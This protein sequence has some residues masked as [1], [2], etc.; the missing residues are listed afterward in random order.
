MP[1][2][3]PKKRPQRTLAN[4]AEQKEEKEKSLSSKRSFFLEKILRDSDTSVS[5]NFFL[6]QSHDSNDSR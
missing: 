5:F 6:F 4:N 3:E 2:T 1:T